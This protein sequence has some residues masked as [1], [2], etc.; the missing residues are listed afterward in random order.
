M[1]EKKKDKGLSAADISMIRSCQTSGDMASRVPCPN[2]IGKPILSIF[3][4]RFCE[5]EWAIRSPKISAHLSQ[6]A[7]LTRYGAGQY[8]LEYLGIRSSVRAN[9]SHEE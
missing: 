9:G 8:D 7:L 3:W 4:E 5:M 6:I 2:R 1:A